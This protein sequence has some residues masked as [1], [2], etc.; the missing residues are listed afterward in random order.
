MSL[1]PWQYPS[2]EALRAHMR[3]IARYNNY[4]LGRDGQTDEGKYLMA[5]VPVL[6]TLLKKRGGSILK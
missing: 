4:R 1:K 6:K 3:W 5:K 2:E